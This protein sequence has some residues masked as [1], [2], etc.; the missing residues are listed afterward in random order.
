[1]FCFA[2]GRTND[3]SEYII[4]INK[5]TTHALIFLLKQHAANSIAL[6]FTMFV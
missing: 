4:V 3:A 6:P 2:N 5:Q 1:M